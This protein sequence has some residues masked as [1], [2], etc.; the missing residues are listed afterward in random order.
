M[1]ISP[2]T[3]GSTNP[4]DRVGVWALISIAIANTLV[5]ALGITARYPLTVGLRSVR[6]GWSTL[7]GSS[8]KVGVVF[9]GIYALLIVGYV[10]ALR[11]ILRLRD[12][13]PHQAV[14]I[15][16]AG[17]LLSSAALLGA[18]PGESFDIFDYVFRGRMI[19]EYSASPLATAPAVFQNQ[20]FYNYITWRGQVDTYGPLW[21]YASGTVAWVV[22]YVFGRADSHVAYI[23]GYRLLAVFLT[24]LCGLLIALIVRRAAPQFVPAALLAWFWNPLVLI[25]TAIGAHNDLLMLVAILAALL[26]FQCQR[27][28]WGLL[29]LA[30]AAHVK[31]T[32]LLVLPILGLWLLRR[33]GW[34]HTLRICALALVFMLPLSWLLYAPLGGWVTLR[35]M[36]QERA[37]LLINSPADLVYRLLQERFGWSELDAWRVTTQAATL[38]FFA[39]AAGILAWFWWADRHAM[40]QARLTTDN[41]AGEGSNAHLASEPPDALLWRG[42]MAV[43]LAYLLI[44]SFWFQH[45]YLLW[46]LTPAVLLPDSRWALTLLPAYCLGAFWSNLTNSFARNQPGFPL[47][48]MQVGAINGLAQV[49]PLL[50]V[51]LVTRIWHDV[52]CLLAAA[53]RIRAASRSTVA[54]VVA[55][56][57]MDHRP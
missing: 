26:L 16:I 42:A 5:Y 53:K 10:V 28:I 15:I 6:A 33:C 39:I 45:W 20:P 8:L 52:P 9:A 3:F 19:V 7:V 31:L 21:E 34:M 54:R 37:R 23:I 18:Y 46:V 1:S 27:W 14:G 24:G 43:T 2:G 29:A 56:H 36:L 17:W 32:A 40:T 51:L 44:G 4:A 12:R 35:R 55:A 13:R 22:H 41:T 47:T 57:E 48:D 49:V 50:C 38:A 30:L 25:T 11:L